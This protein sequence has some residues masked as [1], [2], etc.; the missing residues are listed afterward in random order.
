[1]QKYIRFLL[2]LFT[3]T[4]CTLSTVKANMLPPDTSTTQKLLQYIL[5]PLDKTQVPY[6]FLQEYGCPIFPMATFN[7]TRSDSNKI[8]I[9]L[10]RTLYFQFQTSYCGETP[11]P[12]PDIREVNKMLAKATNDS[13]AISIPILLG[14]YSKIRADAFAT[15]LLSYDVMSGQVF[16]A[17]TREKS[18]YEVE[19]LFIAS[20]SKT[21]SKTNRVSFVCNENLFW[22]NTG[23]NIYKLSINF[24]NGEGFK[25]MIMGTP[26]TISYNKVGRVKWIIKVMMVDSTEFQ[27]YSSFYIANSASILLT[28]QKMLEAQM[29]GIKPSWG[30]ISYT[31]PASHKIYNAQVYIKYCHKN[32]D[33]LLRKPLIIVEGFDACHIAPDLQPNY[34]LKD[35]IKLLKEPMG[36]DFYG[37][38]DNVGCYDIVFIDFEDGTADITMNAKLV[39][40]V[41][42]MVNLNKVIDKKI[43][44]QDVVMGLGMG[45]LCARYGLAEMTKKKENTDT[46][47]L[48]TH[49][50]PHRGL[51]LPLSLQYVIF[52]MDN[53][54]LFSYHLHN[55]YP[56]YN[57]ATNIMKTP[58]MKQMLIYC[59]SDAKHYN[60]NTFLDS[61]YRL[62]ITFKTKDPQPT[63][64]FIA[65]S[66]GNEA[67]NPLFPPGTPFV[68]QIE[69]GGPKEGKNTL[70]FSTPIANSYMLTDI[71]AY[72]LPVKD[73]TVTI[74][75]VYSRIKYTLFGFLN[76]SQDI[77][78]ESI[79]VAG[80]NLMAI[81]G[82]AGSII[83]LH[84]FTD[85]Y[86]SSPQ[87]NFNL[88]AEFPLFQALSSYAYRNS[89]GI[90]PSFTFVPTA[91]AL[92]VNPMT[93]ACFFEK[94]VN[95]TNQYFSPACETF[96][97]QETNG[98][99]GISNNVHARFTARNAEW[100]FNEMENRPNLLNCP[101][102]GDCENN[103]YIDG[104]SLFCNNATFS[105]LGLPRGA[106]V[107]WSVASV[108]EGAATSTKNGNKV[109]INKKKDG[110]IALHAYINNACK[111][112]ISGNASITKV[113]YGGIPK[114]IPINSIAFKSSGAMNAPFMEKSHNIPIYS[115]YI[116]DT[117]FSNMR[118][119]GS[120]S[121]VW[122][123]PYAL[124]GPPPKIIMKDGQTFGYSF[125]KADQMVEIKLTTLNKCGVNQT[126]FE[127][128]PKGKW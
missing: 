76:I 113:V 16:D 104:D 81:D 99:Q 86:I 66:L 40:E 3:C 126:Y 78:D 93:K 83:N 45:G 26:V 4:V 59:A 25:T 63:Y 23:K 112:G 91:S 115:P 105:M 94:Y 43:K 30:N 67:G 109:T 70:F 5:A 75:S 9:N 68:K 32:S 98:L 65:T 95:G 72:S 49:D 42:R 102:N 51:N 62:M 35:F 117:V 54:Q 108:D 27:C 55:I 34:C 7:G 61:I 121:I 44:Q 79:D 111:V 46:R 125:Y 103:Y 116:Y 56:E 92:D 119:V 124:S 88:N 101:F 24:G 114:I 29:E 38:L 14:S 10:W 15:K 12:L 96:I 47:L 118:Y 80:K 17:P 123:N 19:N 84:G 11:N 18:P 6:K 74:A 1:M 122:S 33:N 57:E 13:L 2:V 89:A 110:Y 53:I 39:E 50:S 37:K 97:A 85:E 20:P 73:T 58:A 21:Y 41:V 48:I 52:M 120:S 128:I 90:S 87:P 64:R 100:L 69:D 36:Y 8:D 22:N 127:F 71:E 28:G 77:Y 107:K 106:T 31:A 82:V 60:K